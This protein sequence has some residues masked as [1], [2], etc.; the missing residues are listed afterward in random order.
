MKPVTSLWLAVALSLTGCSGDERTVATPQSPTGT[1]A[2]APSPSPERTG[3]ASTMSQEDAEELVRQLRELADQPTAAKVQDLPFAD[4]VQLGLGDALVKEV[5]AAE[6]ADPAAWAVPV[7]H[8]PAWAWLGDP[9]LNPLE[10]LADDGAYTTNIGPH[11]H[12]ASPPRSAPPEVAEHLR[13]STQPREPQS[14]LAWYT[15]DAFL[16]DG[17]IHAITMDLWEP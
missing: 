2:A 4:T 16:R 10:S 1:P 14:C 17:E 11:P 6:L 8:T 12:C 7:P 3:S 13:I 9:S 15:V 5:S